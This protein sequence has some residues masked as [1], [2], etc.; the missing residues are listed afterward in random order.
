[1][2]THVVSFKLADP[3]DREVLTGMLEALPA[4]IDEIRSLVVGANVVDS[5]RAHDVVLISTF[6][7]LDALRRYQAHPAHQPVLEF[8]EQRTK[9][10]VAVDFES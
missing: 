4:Q 1:M 8:V 6:D 2:I 9:A 7:D 5:P 10:R 3:R